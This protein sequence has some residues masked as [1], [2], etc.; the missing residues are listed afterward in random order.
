MKEFDP[1]T[2]EVFCHSIVKDGMIEFGPDSPNLAEQTV[3]L[4]PFPEDYGI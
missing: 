1:K 3:E 2:Q 4:P